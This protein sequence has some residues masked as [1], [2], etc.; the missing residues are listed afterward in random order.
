[1]AYIILDRD[2]VI[3]YDSD[4]YIKSP[5]EWIAIPG[6]LESIAELNRAGYHVLIV[7]NQSGISRGL[8]D[9]KTL[10]Q[11]HEKLK[12]ELSKMGGV[13][14][15]IFFCPH[16]PSDHCECRKP[17]PGLFYELQKKYPIDFSRTYFIGDSL[18]DVQ[19]AQT[20]GCKPLLV[21]TGK[22]KLTLKTHPELNVL[23]SFPD[24]YE[25]VQFVLNK[26]SKN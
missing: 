20:V 22:G 10:N 17:K 15:E 24:L 23:S 21:L 12:K 5:E 19:A 16:Q 6:S 4:Q 26:R 7:S 18:T 25:A 2:G 11:I 3:N 14:D 13:I 1:M 8:F 9:L